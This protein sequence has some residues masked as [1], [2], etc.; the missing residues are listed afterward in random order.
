MTMNSST[1]KAATLSH[2]LY[3]ELRSAILGGELR[4]GQRLRVSALCKQYGVSLN[5]IREALSRL[6]GEGFVIATPKIG[7]MVFTPSLDDLEDLVKVRIEVETTALRW[8]IKQG[9]VE[10][11]TQ[12]IAA[13]HRLRQSPLEIADEQGIHL[14]PEWLTTHADF[15]MAL[16]AGAESPRL[17]SITR[18]LSDAAQMYRWWSLLPGLH[19]GRDLAAEHVR[20]MDLVLARD[21][22]GAVSALTKHLRVTQDVLLAQPWTKENDPGAAIPSTD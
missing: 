17:L 16:L 5:V 1:G 8:S 20:L 13:H 22:E 21:T 4:P 10:W 3:Q 9:D 14:S 11:E 19:A 6:T 2:E 18:S 7:F 12:I 15:H